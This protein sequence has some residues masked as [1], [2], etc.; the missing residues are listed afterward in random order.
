MRGHTRPRRFD[1]VGRGDVP[2]AP[3]GEVRTMREDLPNED[4][5]T[6]PAPEDPPIEPV[7]PEEP[8][9]RPLPRPAPGNAPLPGEPAP[10]LPGK[11]A[12]T[13]FPPTPPNGDEGREP[14]RL[15]QL[16][17]LPLAG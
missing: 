6:E 9:E 12:P 13:E 1:A 2:P 16:V 15:R 17:Q 7:P 14:D 10:D 8:D 11:P 5:P 3:R 4:P